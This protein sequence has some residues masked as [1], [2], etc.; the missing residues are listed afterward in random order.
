MF[1]VRKEKFIESFKEHSKL[2]N[3]DASPFINALIYGLSFSNLGRALYSWKSEILN[4]L[5]DSADKKDKGHVTELMSEFISEKIKLDEFCIILDSIVNEQVQESQEIKE[6]LKNKYAILRAKAVDYS[7]LK[8]FAVV[9]INEEIKKEILNISKK[10][11]EHK[12]PLP[13]LLNIPCFFINL[14]NVE[15]E[16]EDLEEIFIEEEKFSSLLSYEGLPF[17]IKDAFLNEEKEEIIDYFL[18]I[19]E[20][21]FIYILIKAF[22][23]QGNKVIIVSNKLNVMSL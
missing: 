7:D 2:S 15:E 3:K 5:L 1:K 10:S 11:K 9:T 16:K 20:N 22:D 12:M 14:D 8:V 6:I 13:F 19:D 21:C 17:L 18:M 23:K 4:A